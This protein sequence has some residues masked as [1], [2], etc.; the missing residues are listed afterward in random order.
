MRS[1]IAVGL[2]AV[3]FLAAGCSASDEAKPVAGDLS[4]ITAQSAPQ[5]G[6][7]AIGTAA[8]SDPGAGVWDEPDGVTI[9]RITPGNYP[10]YASRD[11]WLQIALT[12]SSTDDNE[13]DENTDTDLGAAFGWIPATEVKLSVNGATE[14]E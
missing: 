1:P 13:H 8:V 4:L 10:V 14:G 3:A 2:A 5:D 11:G 12:R 9:G 6:L 7:T